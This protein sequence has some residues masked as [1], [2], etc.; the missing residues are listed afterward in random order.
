VLV[1]QL[2][3]RMRLALETL[4]R[5]LLRREVPMQDLHRH[6]AIEGC[7]HPLVDHGHSAL[8]HLL[9]DLVLVDDS[10]DHGSPVLEHCDIFVR[11]RQWP[12]LLGCLLMFRWV[13]GA[14]AALVG[15]GWG[16]PAAAAIADWRVNEVVPSVDGDGGVRYIELFVPPNTAGNC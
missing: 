10:T 15:V 12:P 13:A 14:A 7:I 2:R 5:L 1:A 9:E 11:S 8:A 6:L 16:A 3:D 4:A